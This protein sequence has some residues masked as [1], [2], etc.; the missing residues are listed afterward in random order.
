MTVVFI[1]GVGLIHTYILFL[2]RTQK[3]FI[4]HWI[5]SVVFLLIQSILLPKIV[6]YITE[7]GDDTCGLP[8]LATMLI[9]WIFGGAATIVATTIGFAMWTRRKTRA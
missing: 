5:I 1:L 4:L 8:V 3:T 6:T 9:F 2:L 7:Y